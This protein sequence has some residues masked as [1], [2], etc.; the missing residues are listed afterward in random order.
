[1]RRTL[2]EHRHT[3]GFSVYGYDGLTRDCARFKIPEVPGMNTDLF[4]FCLFSSIFDAAMY[5]IICE[6]P[7]RIRWKRVPVIRLKSDFSVP[8]ITLLGVNTYM[9]IHSS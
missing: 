8:I 6:A 9:Y 2:K 3:R 5:M 1:M 4:L 7:S